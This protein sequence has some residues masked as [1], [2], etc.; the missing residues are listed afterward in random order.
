MSQA[1]IINVAS[2]AGIVTSVTGANGINASPTTG[3]VVV[4]GSNA[5]TSTVGVAFFNPA[6][7]IVSAGG[8][9]SLLGGTTAA[10]QT[11]NGI[12]P[13]SLGNFG[14]LGT[15]NQVAI[16]PGVNQDI[17]SLIGPYTSSS[18][19]AHGVLVG[20]GS[21]SIG[22]V[23]PTAVTGAVLQN[24][25]GLDPS[26]SSASYPSSTIANQ[27]LYSSATN[28]ISG[29]GT[30]SNG[31]LITG[32]SGIPA[33]LVNGTTGQVLTATTGSPPTWVSPATSGTVT[34]VSGTANQVAVAT[35]TTTPV[36]S[37]IGPY[38]PATYT[39]HSVLVGE[40]TSSIIGIGP[41]ATS[42]QVFQNNAGADPSYSTATYPSTTTINQILYSS[43]ANTVVGLSSA[44]NGVLITS[45]T[46]VPSIL[47]DGTTG[48]VLTATT[49]SPPSWASPATSGTVTSVSG[50]TNQ[51]AVATG[52]TTP[53]ISLIGP[54]TPAT[55]TTHGVLLGEGTSSISTVGPTATTGQVLQ[56]NAS[57]DPTYSTATYPSTTTIS[58]I[59]YSSSSNTITGLATAN[60]AVLTTNSSGV[61]GFSNALPGSTSGTGVAA[62]FI[63]QIITSNV[64][65]GSAVALSNSVA[66]NVTS[67]SLT[68]GNWM[69]SGI[70]IYTDTNT[71]F[72]VFSSGISSVSATLQEPYVELAPESSTVGSQAG[73]PVNNIFVSLSSSTTYYLVGSAAFISGAVTAFGQ[74]TAIRIG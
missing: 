26:Y 64:P 58:Q 4:S 28:V 55:Y 34:S 23:G 25:S 14:L 38:T 61:P 36:I 54:Y 67:I 31:V 65:F 44:N 6:E 15:T 11:I 9:V 27:L 33:F 22:T 3:A 17:I 53:V 45:A 21:S 19:T 13:N 62:G 1:G 41:S 56:N 10:I 52:T 18:F 37:L 47:P 59:L 46:G 74:I 5:T 63:G 73:V 24:N 66:A 71:G 39:A 43:A 70:I 72:Q 35:G 68:A 42:G 48:Q 2:S 20:E 60:S 12:G 29:L 7:F 30:I 50:T 40:G 32:S 49:G 8:Q 57:A 16:T 69:I 51:V